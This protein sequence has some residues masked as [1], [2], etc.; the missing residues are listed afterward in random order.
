MKLIHF[1]AAVL[2]L[3]G[4]CRPANITENKPITK[5][6]M[7][8]DV[9]HHQGKIDWNKLSD[10]NKIGFVYIKAT[11]GS[12]YKDPMFL[13]NASKAKE[14]GLLVGAYHF[15]RMT[16]SPEEQFRNFKKQI[17]KIGI[18]LIP[19]V[20]VET[21]DKHSRKDVQKNLQ[22]LLDLLEKEYGKKPM[23]YGTN[24]SYNELCA[25]EFNSYPLYIGRYGDNCPVITGKGHYTIWQ[26]TEK[27][28]VDGCDKPIDLCKF[29]QDCN[30]NMIIL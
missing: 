8:I 12:S 27:G 29:H 24:R 7:G 30:I 23:I 26:Y 25:P 13:T 5:D 18:D 21:A 4:G 20:D 17:D 19:M 16:S 14:S 28:N 3:L 1:I 9:S 22:T 15:F 2:T 6:V 10:N 11:E